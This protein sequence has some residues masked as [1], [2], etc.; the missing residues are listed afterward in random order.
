MTLPHLANAKSDSPSFP[1]H[2][3]AQETNNGL[4]AFD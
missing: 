2:E 3:D 1:K 4:P